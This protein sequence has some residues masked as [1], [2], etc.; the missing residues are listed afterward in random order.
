MKTAAKVFIIL[1]MVCQFFTII[2]LIV[3][4]IALSKMK[5]Q[6]PS[7]GL[8]VCVLLFCNL[9]GGILLLCSK[10]EDFAVPAAPVAEAPAEEKADAE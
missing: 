4:F 6:K 1:G 3:G 2:P 5:T 10:E 7:T 8:S 9:I